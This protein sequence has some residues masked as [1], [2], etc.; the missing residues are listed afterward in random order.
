MNLNTVEE[1]KGALDIS[2]NH[3]NTMKNNVHDKYTNLQLEF[4]NNNIQLC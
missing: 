1:P 4:Q 3:S 2:I